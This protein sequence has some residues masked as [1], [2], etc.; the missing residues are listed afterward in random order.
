MPD[1]SQ[2]AQR[3]YSTARRSTNT[4]RRIEYEALASITARMRAAAQDGAAGF[5][6]L[7]R[8]LYDNRRLWTIFGIHAAS[9][10]NP[11][12]EEL[13]AGL[14]SLSEFVNQHSS[15]FLQRSASV[16]SLLEINTSVMRGL[17]DGAR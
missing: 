9:G 2:Q 6:A 8:A 3:A 13:R 7:A 15:K 16:E 12:P 5:P 1:A 4:P 11:L 10:S 17:K 14:V